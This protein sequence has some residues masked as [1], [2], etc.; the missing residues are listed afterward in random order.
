MEPKNLKW[1]QKT[2]VYQIYP[3][4][5]KDSTGNGIGDLRGIISKLESKHNC[6]INIKLYTSPEYARIK[7]EGTPFYFEVMAN[8]LI[9]KGEL[10]ET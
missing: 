2:V 7:S 5:Y 3:R 4:S 8:N 1:W 9:L 6:Q 10:D